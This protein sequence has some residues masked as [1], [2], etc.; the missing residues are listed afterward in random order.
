MQ[1]GRSGVGEGAG[2]F[3]AWGA[4]DGEGD[5]DEIPGGALL[6]LPS[7]LPDELSAAAGNYFGIVALWVLCR[8]AGG[9]PD[10]AAGGEAEQG[11]GAGWGGGGGAGRGAEGGGGGEE[12]AGR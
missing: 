10:E 8:L 11:A 5:G 3:A 6:P 1:E 7:A 9:W 12:A 2:A 4:G